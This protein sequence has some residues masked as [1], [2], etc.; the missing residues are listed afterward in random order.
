MRAYKRPGGSMGTPKAQCILVEPEATLI[1]PKKPFL[2]KMMLKNSWTQSDGDRVVSDSAHHLD[3]SDIELAK[4][5]ILG[6]EIAD[7]PFVYMSRDESNEL[8]VDPENLAFELGGLAHVYVE[9]SR[10]FSR[11][12]ASKCERRNPYGGSIGLCIT[13]RGIIRKFFRRFSGDDDRSIAEVLALIC[14][15][16]MLHVSGVHALDWSG[17]QELQ[18][19]NLRKTL[20]KELSTHENIEN[21]E[22]EKYAAAFDEEIGAKDDQIREL[23]TALKEA[24]D[25]TAALQSPDSGLLN[26]D[27]LR[28]AAKELYPGETSDRIRKLISKTL[29]S[30][31]PECSNRDQFVF[32]R[33]LQISQPSGKSLGLIERVKTAGRD[34]STMP[35]RLGG[36]LKEIGFIQTQDGKHSKFTPPTELGGLAIQMLPK[37]PSDNRAGKNKATDIIKCFSINELH[38]D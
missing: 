30:E 12:L 11:R 24:R 36:L 29:S 17:L 3:S 26:Q 37:T 20:H 28:A 13:S 16:Q 21:S 27:L 38:K 31:S 6:E 32:N 1:P 15:K 5:I 22:F 34:A 18:T 10:E 35:K 7:L 2:V 4:R 8:L 33:L 23:K 9:T 19:R 25:D 14:T